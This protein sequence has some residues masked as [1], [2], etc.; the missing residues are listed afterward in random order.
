MTRQRWKD[1]LESVGIIAIIASL[2]FVGIETR[3]STRQAALTTQALE[4][5]AY[6]DLN[7]NIEEMNILTMHSDAAASTMAKV[8]MEPGDIE[9]FRERRAIFLLLRHGDMAF[10]MYERGAIDES[11]LR[12]A[13]APITFDN[14]MVRNHWEK[15]KLSF[16]E[17]YRDYIDALIADLDGDLE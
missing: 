9:S 5:T 12:S 7:T 8:W 4:I 13:I 3:N 14:P 6:Q 15:Y 2:I 1:A 10:Y 11:R 16:A 17:E